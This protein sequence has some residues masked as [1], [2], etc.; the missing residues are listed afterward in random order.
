ML[1]DCIFIFYYVILV[2]VGLVFAPDYSVHPHLA[3]ET[4]FHF[5][6]FVLPCVLMELTKSEVEK[7]R[8]IFVEI[9]ALSSDS[10]IS[11]IAEDALKFLEKVPFEFTLWRFASVN[12]RLPLQF[13]GL[14]TTYVIVSIQF[15]H[16]FG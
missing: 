6:K 7:I 14:M 15:M 11:A 3:A 4:I 13:L 16:V 8:I 2:A 9:T 12:I 5:V 1:K 10:K